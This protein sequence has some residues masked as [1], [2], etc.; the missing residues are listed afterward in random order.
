MLIL[1][2]T[3]FGCPLVALKR[4]H[5]GSTSEYQ[6]GKKAEKELCTITV[7][8]TLGNGPTKM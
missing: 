8:E 1:K 3:Q 2:D 4:W 6:E 7:V 5:Q